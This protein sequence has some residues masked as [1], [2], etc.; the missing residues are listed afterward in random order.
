MLGAARR[1]AG[2]AIGCARTKGFGAG[3]MVVGDGP[4]GL[5]GDLCI[6]S[7]ST[8]VSGEWNLTLVT[9]DGLRGG[10]ERDLVTVQQYVVAAVAAEPNATPDVPTI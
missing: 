7:N 9:L 5:V 6:M 2:R 3:T 1:V 8:R 10:F 4:S